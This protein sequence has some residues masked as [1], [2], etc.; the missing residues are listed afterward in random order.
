MLI[1]QIDI[2]SASLPYAGGSYRLSGGR[3]Y[4]AFEATIAKVTTN[5]GLVG[6]GE[7]TPFGATYI[8]AHAGSVRAGL[9]VLA[10]AVMGLDPRCLDRINAAMDEALLGTLEAKTAIDVACWDIFGKAAGMPVCD[11]LG[12][13]IEQSIPLISSIPVDT[14]RAMRASVADYRAR[15]FGGH[16]VKIGSD[17]SEGGPSTDAARLAACLADRQPGEWFLADAN[18]SMTPE[19]VLRLLKLL[20]DGLDFVLEAP[21]ANWRETLSL[22]QRCSVPILLDELIQS[23]QDAIFAIS[24]D[25]C[26][27]LGIKISKQGGLTRSRR[28]RD[29]CVSAGLVAST[30]E[31]VGSTIAFAALLHLAQSTPAKTLRC[32]LDTRA[33]VSRQLADFDAPIQNGGVTAPNEPGLGMQVHEQDLG[34]PIM[35][36][37]AK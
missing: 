1:Q 14:P 25:A 20:P 36:F 9:Q 31:T 10:P 32:A 33:M 12:G 4:T 37:G 13:R 15:G 24:Q 7:S 27:G 8:N 23:E 16:S 21:C 29:L 5:T 6:W 18:N 11:L 22:R 30:Q 17:E 34:A 28:L 35:T 2:Y 26:D 19:Q 3:V